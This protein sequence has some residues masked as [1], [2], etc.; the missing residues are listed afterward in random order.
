M[1]DI[2]N[3]LYEELS[4]NNGISVV[5][6]EDRNFVIKT[7]TDYCYA[8]SKLTGRGEDFYFN[9]IKN[10]GLIRF[11]LT[12]P[13]VEFFSPK[14]HCQNF[15]FYSE[16]NGKNICGIVVSDE[17]KENR[18]YDLMHQLTHFIIETDIDNNE[19][20]NRTDFFEDSNNR[21]KEGIVEK[22]TQ[23][24][25]D[26]FYKNIESPGSKESRY[27]VEYEVATVLMDVMGNADFLKLIVDNPTII[28]EKM[29]SISY[30]N[31]NL[32]DYIEKELEPLVPFRGK[33]EKQ[34][35]DVY[36]ILESVEAIS[37]CSKQLVLKMRR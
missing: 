37:D 19:I 26:I 12:D 15:N 32:F 22:I 3:L 9:K 17:M 7:M 33:N 29:K 20:R 21:L 4:S 28:L 23:D 25:W 10:I 18:C 11:S 14:S 16:F 13:D 8:M 36:G 5:K 27:F 6:E 34:S 30:Q 31:T 24:A 2:Y 35:V 1:K